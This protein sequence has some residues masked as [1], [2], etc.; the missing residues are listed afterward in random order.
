[1][2]NP[3]QQAYP[4]V[5]LQPQGPSE[6]FYEPSSRPQIQQQIARIIAAE[7]PIK[8]D[9]LIRRV[10]NEWGFNRVATKIRKTVSE[11]LPPDLAKTTNGNESVYWPAEQEPN[12]YKHYR[13]ADQ[14]IRKLEDT[15][16]IELS[17]DAIPHSPHQPQ[18]TAW[19]EALYAVQRDRQT[20]R[21]HPR[22]PENRPTLRS[23][24]PALDRRTNYYPRRRQP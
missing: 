19:S 14:D 6:N 16:L 15:P 13:V 5:V 12:D 1:M 18:S 2:A 20:P 11:C 23:R 10:A 7:G 17:N 24:R 22:H 8:E 9:L 3:R 4:E 21:L